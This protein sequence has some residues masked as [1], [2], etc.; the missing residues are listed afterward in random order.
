[1]T[2]RPV[3]PNR[4][5]VSRELGRGGMGTVLLARDNALER[6]VAIKV[7]T[8][9]LAQ[10]LGTE[11]FLREIHLTAQ[12]VHPNIVPLFDSGESEGWLYYVMPFID[13]AT[14]RASLEG[15]KV[16][17]PRVVTRILADTAEAL[18]YAHGLGVVHR[19]VKPENI[20]WYGGRAL[21]AD[22]GIA[23]GKRV[24]PK[25]ASLTA[26][27]TIVGTVSYMSPEQAGGDVELDGRADLY[28]LG[29]VAY[30]LLIGQPPFVRPNAM[31]TLAAHLTDDIPRLRSSRA[32]VDPALAALVEQLLAK[33]R[34]Q[35]PR[36]AAAVLD[37]LR[38]LE[39]VSAAPRISASVKRPAASDKPGDPPAVRELTAKVRELF[40]N[41]MQGGEGTRDK[42]LMARVYGEKAVA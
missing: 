9:D 1:V 31:A 39:H 18:A 4:F 34:D 12:L 37:A 2:L 14:L 23:T 22:F 6:D 17:E 8:P 7:L 41:A 25:D 19:D 3:L 35:R 10:A 27:G 26:T 24:A 21:L 20:F 28:S 33:E 15:G 36:D 40:R 5:T 32:D 30:E 42:L 29:C 13:G 16:L 38:P 11:R